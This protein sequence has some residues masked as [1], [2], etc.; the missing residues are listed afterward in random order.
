MAGLTAVLMTSSRR[1]HPAQRKLNKGK[2]NGVTH[3]KADAHVENSISHRT[4]DSLPSRARVSHAFH[5]VHLPAL[6]RKAP[7]EAL[8]PQTDY[9][10]RTSGKVALTV[11]ESNG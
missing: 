3:K 1:S 4:N 5:E 8:L 2:S 7:R 9:S 6:T 11:P 10:E